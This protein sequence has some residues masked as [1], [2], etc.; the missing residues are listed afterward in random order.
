[1]IDKPISYGRQYISDED[2]QAVVDTLRS[3]YLTCGPAIPAFEKAFS[4]YVHCEYA[5]AVNNATSA[6]HLAAIALGVKS[7]DNVICTPL[8][9]AS[10][11]NCI[12]FCGGKFLRLP[13]CNV[14]CIQREDI[15]VKIRESAISYSTEGCSCII[16]TLKLE[17][18]E[19]YEFIYK[20]M[21]EEKE[22]K[23][24]ER[25]KSVSGLE[26]LLTM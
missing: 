25:K 26:D 15:P 8:T 12:R 17:E 1:M 19:N 4:E 24:L 3:D 18:V 14:G 7:G 11:A 21:I 9:F 2:I 20:S 23:R 10:S 22:K 13:N 16:T 6:L 5:V